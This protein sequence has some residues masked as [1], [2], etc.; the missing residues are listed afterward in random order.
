M[1]VLPPLAMVIVIGCLGAVREGNAQQP[2]PAP[3]PAAAP[4]N[5]IGNGSFEQAGRQNNPWSGLDQQGF[6][7]G[8][9]GTVPALTQ[10]G[11]IGD[12]AMPISVAIADMNGDGKMDIVT[13]D[14]VGYFRVYFNQGTPEQPKFDDGE[15]IPVFL[16][17]SVAQ[18]YQTAELTRYRAQ[19]IYV[20]NFAKS[21]KND[22]LIGNYI[23]EV[24][25]LKNEGTTTSPDFRQP[26]SRASIAIPTTEDSTRRWGNLFAPATWDWNGDG[27]YDLM[28]GEGSYSANAIHLLL[29]QGTANAPRFN[30]KN[31]HFLTG[32]VVFIILNYDS[33]HNFFLL[34]LS[35]ASLKPPGESPSHD[36]QIASAIE[37]AL[38]S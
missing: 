14:V 1:R 35:S 29:N 21:G 22:M 10:S 32:K 5:L 28:L 18:N 17:R 2:T 15:L 3:A 31:H 33:F 12:T 26:K 37:S 24:L 25:S 6:L 4:G 7:K 34:P 16:T 20:G 30:E 8:L 36:D 23:G 27:R 13:S 9:G 11:T 19:R 38:H